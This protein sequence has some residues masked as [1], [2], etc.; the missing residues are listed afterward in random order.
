MDNRLKINFGEFS[1]KPFEEQITEY[2]SHF[3]KT[4]I[5]SSLYFSCVFWLS[6]LLNHFIEMRVGYFPEY[7]DAVDYADI[8]KERYEKLNLPFAIYKAGKIS[9]ISD[10]FRD[11]MNKDRKTN[12][13]KENKQ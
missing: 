1:K 7:F 3:S 2:L 13:E 11:I 5:D 10:E 9:Y 4:A 8:I 12:N 6:P